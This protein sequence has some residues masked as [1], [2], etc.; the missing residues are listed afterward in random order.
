[1]SSSSSSYQISMSA[2]YVEGV[3]GPE[4]EEGERKKSVRRLECQNRM[5]SLPLALLPNHTLS[6]EELGEQ[7]EQIRRRHCV[8]LREEEKERKMMS[9]S[10]FF[11]FSV[12]TL[13]LAVERERKEPS[14]RSDRRRT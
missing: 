11:F 6:G 8:A 7:H 9:F 3:S 5:C 4:E 2:A 13:R 10:F 12:L 14:T 1:M